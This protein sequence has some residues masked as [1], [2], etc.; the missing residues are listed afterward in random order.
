MHH[1]YLYNQIIHLRLK[2]IKKHAP[3]QMHALSLWIYYLFDL[4]LLYNNPRIF[5][6][7]YWC[8]SRAC[9]LIRSAN[10][11]AELEHKNIVTRNGQ[12]LK[13]NSLPNF[14]LQLFFHLASNRVFKSTPNNGISNNSTIDAWLKKRGQSSKTF[15]TL[16]RC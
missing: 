15:Y 14:V 7:R 9:L 5:L 1:R 11:L 6:R 8:Y 12:F 10:C 2:A 13:L 3:N 4:W 16:G